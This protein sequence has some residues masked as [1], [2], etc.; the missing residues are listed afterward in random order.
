MYPARKYNLVGQSFGPFYVDSFAGKG[1]MGVY[2]WNAVIVEG[3]N[4]GQWV[5]ADKQQLK[6]YRSGDLASVRRAEALAALGS[7]WEFGR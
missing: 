6:A 7:F 3:P 5:I 1:A 4:L 2:L